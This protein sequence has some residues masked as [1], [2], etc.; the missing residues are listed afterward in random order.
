MKRQQMPESLCCCSFLFLFM[1][2]GAK[3]I[4]SLRL[5]CAFHQGNMWVPV[6]VGLLLRPLCQFFHL[7]A[8]STEG[9]NHIFGPEPQVIQC[10]RGI[11]LLFSSH[12]FDYCSLRNGMPGIKVL[13]FG[14]RLYI[15]AALIGYDILYIIGWCIW[16]YSVAVFHCPHDL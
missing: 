14:N 12:T 5:F 7:G 10:G 16:I 8:N 15:F 4:A 9:N 13:I 2:C 11:Q 6:L 1:C 3:K